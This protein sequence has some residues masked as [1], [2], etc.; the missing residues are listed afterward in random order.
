MKIKTVSVVLHHKAITNGKRSDDVLSLHIVYVK[1][2][3]K[4]LYSR[5]IRPHIGPSH[6]SVTV[7]HQ[8]H[9]DIS[10]PRTAVVTVTLRETLPISSFTSGQSL[11]LTVQ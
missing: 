10:E 2:C 3:N 1:S 9:S 4:D 6:C 11:Y 7:A 5:V 8:I